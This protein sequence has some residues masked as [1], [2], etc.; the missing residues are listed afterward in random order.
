[1]RIVL[2]GLPGAGKTTLGTRLSKECN[3]PFIPEFACFRAEELRRY[4]LRAPFYRINEET[5]EY[6]GNCFT[7][8]VIIFDRHYIGVLA[9]AFSLNKLQGPNENNENYE[10][11]FSWYQKGLRSGSLT[12]A[13]HIIFLDIPAELS[14]ERQPLAQEF[15]PMFGNL[16]FL[17]L[18][19]DYYHYFFQ[20]VEPDL[21]VTVL[22]GI[23]SEEEIFSKVINYIFSVM[24]Q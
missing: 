21:K 23:Q 10:S 3:L 22:S 11:E 17:K 20:A 2:E 12:R 18:I 24:P 6:I 19:Q 15:D 13:D 14:L 5:K 4:N 16:N 1:M 8:P 9:F 7:E